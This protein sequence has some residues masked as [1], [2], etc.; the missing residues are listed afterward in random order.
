[1]CRKPDHRSVRRDARW[2]RNGRSI[3]ARS[4]ENVLVQFAPFGAALHMDTRF[5]RAH[6]S[7]A[8]GGEDMSDGTLISPTRL[9]DGGKTGFQ[10]SL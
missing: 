4:S 1:M 9:R 7:A 8:C 3:Y 6:P 5:A 10:E 2:A